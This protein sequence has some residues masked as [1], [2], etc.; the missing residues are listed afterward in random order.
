MGALIWSTFA[1]REEARNITGVLLKEQLIACANMVDIESTFL[2]DGVV[3]DGHECGALFKTSGTLL[4]QAVAR[5]EQLHPYEI[6]AILG[7]RCDSTA[8]QTAAWLA[9]LAVAGGS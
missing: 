8:A 3:S 9:A 1:N 6:P 5:I 2:W 4:D 7:W